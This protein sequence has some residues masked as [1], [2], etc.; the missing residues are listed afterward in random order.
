METGI[1]GRT[2]VIEGA[3]FWNEAAR[4]LMDPENPAPDFRRDVSGT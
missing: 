3:V 2:I 1:D 4:A